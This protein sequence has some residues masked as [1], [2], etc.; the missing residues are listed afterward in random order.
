MKKII[1]SILLIPSLSYATDIEVNINNIKPIVGKLFIALDVKDTYDK[2]DKSNSFFSLRKKVLASSHKIIISDVNP[3]TYALS[4]FH[5]VD[6]N[7]KLST[8][9]FGV[10]SEGYG[11]SNNVVGSFSMPTFKEASFI[12]NNKQKIISLNVELV[13]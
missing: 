1:L 7:N 13:R 6:N 2:D 11:F 9:F 8:N 4:V 3:G 5:D 10:P 12:I